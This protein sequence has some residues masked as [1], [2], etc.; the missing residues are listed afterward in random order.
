MLFLFFLLINAGSM[1]YLLYYTFANQSD[2]KNNMIT[3]IL[4]VASFVF[5]GLTFVVTLYYFVSDYL[6][7]KIW[8][9]ESYLMRSREE[10]PKPNMRYQVHPMPSVEEL[11]D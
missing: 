11:A 2:V 5:L 9:L 10:Q 8:V 4:I 6:V 7:E 3:L 1:S